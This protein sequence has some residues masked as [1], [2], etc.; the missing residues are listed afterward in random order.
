MMLPEGVGGYS[1]L[2]DKALPANTRARY[3]TP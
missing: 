1:K 3:M 2:L